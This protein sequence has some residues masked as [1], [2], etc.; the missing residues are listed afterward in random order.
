VHT[1]IE[2]L[3]WPWAPGVCVTVL[4][5]EALLLTLLPTKLLGRRSVRFCAMFVCFCLAAGE[6][7]MVKLDRSA[8]DARHR[9]DMEAIF[10]RFVK[11]DQDIL[12][13]QT[14]ARATE[15]SRSL[16]RDNLKRQALDLSNEIL[17]FL[18]SREIPPGYG[19]GGFGAGP[20][21]GKPSDTTQ[22]DDETLR[23]Y[24][25]VFQPRVAEMRDELKKR[26]LSDPRLE[27]EFPNPVNTYSI[28]AIA[29]RIA[30]LAEK[31]PG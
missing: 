15:E 13:L 26:G 31:A 2:C 11:L 28:R 6:I 14:N 20:Y 17:E 30:A 18:I 24:L 27:V 19:Q 4:A 9:Q 22:Y 23:S 29:E 21:G 16:P 5:V 12:A 7:L 25:N 3:H 10:A 8:S 1:L